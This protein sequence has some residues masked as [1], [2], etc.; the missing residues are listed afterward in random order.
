M[1]LGAT[2]ESEHYSG[3]LTRWLSKGMSVCGRI[4]S[5]FLKGY[6]LVLVTKD[7]LTPFLDLHSIHRWFFSKP[8]SMIL[9]N[10]SKLS[11]DA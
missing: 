3:R 8:H 10:S 6:D 7:I 5:S 1:I 9:H 11:F 2:I 4:V